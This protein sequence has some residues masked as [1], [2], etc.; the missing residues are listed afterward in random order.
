MKRLILFGAPG[1]G[2][3]TMGDFIQRDFHFL[4]ISTGDIIRRE[5]QKASVIGLQAKEIME[6]GDLIPDAVVIKIVRQRLEIKD[7]CDGYIMDGFP[8]NLAQAEALTGIPVEME[9]AFFFEVA[10]TEAVERLLSRLTCNDCGAIYNL[11][12]KLPKQQGICDLCQG[13]VQRRTDDNEEVIKQRIKIYFAQTMPAIEYYQRKN[14]LSR[15]DGGG[16]SHLVYEKIKGL[17]A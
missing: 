3:G 5:I 16:A 4:K 2:K 13:V 1:S 8:R 17:I 14:V 11:I 12:T 7:F 15:I 10:E 9:R 6:K